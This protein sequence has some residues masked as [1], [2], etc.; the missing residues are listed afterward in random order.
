MYFAGGATNKIWQTAERIG[1]GNYFWDH[2][3]PEI[4]DDHL[5]VN[6]DAKIP[7]VD[8]IEYKPNAIKGGYFGNYHHTHDDNMDIIDKSTLKAVG[9]T[10]MEVIW[11][12]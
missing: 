5:Y 11:N 3:S 9:Q 4:T 12:E 8:I 10:V 2:F 6:R 7:M 1:F